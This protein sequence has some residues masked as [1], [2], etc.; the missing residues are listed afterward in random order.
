MMH[1]LQETG[2]SNDYHNKS[3]GHAGTSGQESTADYSHAYSVNSPPPLPYSYVTPSLALQCK[4]L[5]YE[6]YRFV[7]LGT[8]FRRRGADVWW[9][10]S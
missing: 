2:S 1:V 5:Q 7:P 8:E 6:M 4:S 9:I 10:H 3:V